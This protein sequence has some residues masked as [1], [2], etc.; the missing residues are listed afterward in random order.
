MG[1]KLRP[2]KLVHGICG[3]RRIHD[4]RAYVL[5]EAGRVRAAYRPSVGRSE[6]IYL[7]VAQGGSNSVHI[8][9]DVTAPI[10]T[11]SSSELRCTITFR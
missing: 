6:I 1:A 5:T 2:Y 4:N 7:V 9:G 8:L 3:Q 10:P 11:G